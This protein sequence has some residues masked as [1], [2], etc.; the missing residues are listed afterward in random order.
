MTIYIECISNEKSASIEEKFFWPFWFKISRFPIPACWQ[1]PVCHPTNDSYIYRASIRESGI[2]IMKKCMKYTKSAMVP[3]A[4]RI[5]WCACLMCFL[6]IWLLNLCH[7]CTQNAN[8][9]IL[10]LWQ[11]YNQCVGWLVIH[12]TWDQEWTVDLPTSFL[13]CRSMDVDVYL[14][15][16]NFGTMDWMLPG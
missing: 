15:W 14:S 2:C 3:K 5:T 16:V 10:H 12:Y 7:F 1:E 11:Y 6:S 13:S 8:L 9:I 4:D